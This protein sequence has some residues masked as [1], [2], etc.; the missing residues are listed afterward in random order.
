[1]IRFP[2]G[3]DASA[4]FKMI[5]GRACENINTI[6]MDT[7]AH[8]AH[9]LGRHGPEQMKFHILTAQR[10]VRSDLDQLSLETFAHICVGWAWSMKRYGGCV[11]AWPIARN[12]RGVAVFLPV[13]PFLLHP[14]T[15]APAQRRRKPVKGNVVSFLRFGP[16][17]LLYAGDKAV[18]Q[19]VILS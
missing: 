6:D 18:Y 13:L 2:A 5:G 16:A 12:A 4:L 15:M 1:M 11:S 17:V 9:S 10:L 3:L 7:V 8:L 14:H 19:P